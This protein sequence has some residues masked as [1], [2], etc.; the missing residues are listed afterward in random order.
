MSTKSI[1]IKSTSIN[2]ISTFYIAGLNFFLVPFLL[3][4]LGAVQYGLIGIIN[5]FT[6]VGYVSLFE[7]GFASA[8]PK[9]V[10]EYKAKNKY[11]SINETLNSFII[12]FIIIGIVVNLMIYPAIDV[13]TYNWFEIP[14][15]FAD[16]FIKVFHLLLASLVFQFPLLILDAILQGFSRFDILKYSQM[17]GET[18][19][20]GF[21]F[22]FVK[23]GGGFEVVIYCNI[24]LSILLLCIYFISITNLLPNYNIKNISFSHFKYINKLAK[25]LLLGRLSSLLANNI[26]RI[27]IAL[28]LNPLMMTNYD[29]LFKLPQVLNKFLGMANTAITPIASELYAKGELF[30]ITELYHRGFRFYFSFNTPIILSLIYFSNYFIKFWV[31][32]EY[33]YLTEY[34]QLLLIWSLLTPLIFGGNILTGINKGMNKLT[35]IRWLQTI[36]KISFLTILIK[37]YQIMGVVIS[38]LASYMSLILYLK[39]YNKTLNISGYVLLKDCFLIISTSALPLLILTLFNKY[40]KPQHMLELFLFIT[41]WCFLQWLL[42]YIYVLDNEDKFT[43]KETVY[44]LKNKL[45]RLSIK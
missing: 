1:L 40:Y 43:V 38:Y 31:G 2:T 9:L 27:L 16:K 33:I 3:K 20:I 5:I 26:D 21:I 17:V 32:E 41:I 29:I 28:Y 12:I 10:A 44:N 24:G 4:N 6:I 23:L 37:E 7:L 13:I 39:L 8:L 25:L 11:K 22:Y 18:L 36:L 42:I 34:L 45:I 19:K 30:K 14:E 15:K 35:G